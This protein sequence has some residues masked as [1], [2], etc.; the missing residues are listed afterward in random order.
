MKPM[1]LVYCI[2]D[3][4]DENYLIDLLIEKDFHLTKLSS[5]GGF[6]H[7]SN[8]T[9]L[10]GVGEERL[11][12][13]LDTIKNAL[14]PRKRTLPMNPLISAG[15]HHMPLSAT[16]VKGGCICFVMDAEGYRF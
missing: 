15:V 5:S 2:I 1:K 13:A 8:T 12:E 4:D 14:E 9:L 6:L 10:M 16:F 7:K 3:P 11:E